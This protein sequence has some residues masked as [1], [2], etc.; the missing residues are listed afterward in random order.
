MD[1]YINNL[2]LESPLINWMDRTSLIHFWDHFDDLVSFHGHHLFTHPSLIYCWM[3]NFLIVAWQ[4]Y[5]Q[6]DFQVI[7][8]NLLL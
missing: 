6:K 7:I 8:N 1:Y 2:D 4:E 3:Q 5:S